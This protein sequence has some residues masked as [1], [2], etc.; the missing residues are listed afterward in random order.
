[1]KLIIQLSIICGICWIS[2]CIESALPIAIPASI[3]GMVLLLALLILRVIKLEW[4]QEFANVLLGNLS[5]FFVPAVVSIV[6]YLDILK[7]SF[8]ALITICVVTMFV[9]FAAAVCAVRLTLRWQER[10]KGL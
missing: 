3:I 8:L 7:N 2:L 4:V 5:F 10:G 9:T 1:M 6:K